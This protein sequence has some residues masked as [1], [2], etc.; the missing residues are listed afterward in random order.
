MW[1]VVW[2]FLLEHAQRSPTMAVHLLQAQRITDRLG[3]E[4]WDSHGGRA[5]ST[6]WAAIPLNVLCLAALLFPLAP[7][8]LVQEHADHC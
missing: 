4:V 7:I 2:E 6:W 8:S 1:N 3:E 5:C